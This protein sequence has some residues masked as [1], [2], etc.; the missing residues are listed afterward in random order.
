M[1]KKMKERDDESRCECLIRVR[2]EKGSKEWEEAKMHD[3]RNGSQKFW[4]RWWREENSWEI[5]FSHI[6][7]GYGVK[8]KREN[9]WREEINK[10]RESNTEGEREKGN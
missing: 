1:K 5:C 7:E 2:S 10:K 9:K 6:N 3:D 4:L 8:K